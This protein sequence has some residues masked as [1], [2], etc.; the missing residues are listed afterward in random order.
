MVKK[1]LI[2]YD[3]TSVLDVLYLKGSQFDVSCNKDV[4]HEN[5]QLCPFLLKPAATSRLHKFKR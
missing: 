5:V 3:A 1:K 2:A 4:V